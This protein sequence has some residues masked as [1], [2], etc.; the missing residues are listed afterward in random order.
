MAASLGDALDG[1]VDVVLNLVGLDEPRSTALAALV[2]PGG[3]I[4]SVTNE[5]ETPIAERVVAR[6]D[7]AHLVEL[8]ALVDSGTI[9]VEVTERHGFSALTSLH[10][11]SEAGGI[12]GKIIV[13]PTA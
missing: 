11:R 3:R 6:N 1:Q 13:Q 10:R 7:S 9:T 4:V 8:V 2:R 5:F 12:R